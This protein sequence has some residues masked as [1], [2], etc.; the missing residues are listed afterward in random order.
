M[1][2]VREAWVQYPAQEKEAKE[3]GN[4]RR[5]EASVTNHVILALRRVTGSSGYMRKKKMPSYRIG[6]SICRSYIC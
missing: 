2:T 6:E 4:R 3:E 1:P 5:R